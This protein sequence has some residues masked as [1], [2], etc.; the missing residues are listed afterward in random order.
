MMNVQEITPNVQ[1]TVEVKNDLDWIIEEC[2]DF[3]DFGWM[4][5]NGQGIG[6]S[7]MSILYND[8]YAAWRK[9]PFAATVDYDMGYV[10]D[11]VEQYIEYME[12]MN[13]YDEVA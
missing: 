11:K 7:D 13:D 8:I 9:S 12:F 2:L 3:A 10:R 1:M 4:I 6:T 5:A